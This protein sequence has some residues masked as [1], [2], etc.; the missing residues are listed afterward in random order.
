MAAHIVRIL[1]GWAK[2]DSSPA[3]VIHALSYAPGTDSLDME[4][5]EA[6]HAAAKGSADAES[7]AEIKRLAL[8][9]LPKYLTVYFSLDCPRNYEEWNARVYERRHAESHK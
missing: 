5:W 3:N 8:S 2:D 4:D 9:L 6:L 7:R 1:H